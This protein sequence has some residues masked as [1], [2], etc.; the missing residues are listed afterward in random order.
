MAESYSIV[1]THRIVFL[2]SSVGGHLACFHVLAVVNG[3][4]GARG[5]F[6]SVFFSACLPRAEMA[7]SHSRSLFSFLR[8]LHSVLRSGCAHVQPTV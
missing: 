1:Y 3:A 8:N 6:Q 7:G 5:S 4:A 2:H